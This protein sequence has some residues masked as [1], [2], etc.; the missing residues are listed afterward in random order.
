MFQKS[1]F[2]IAGPNAAPEGTPVTTFVEPGFG[3][4]D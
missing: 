1:V 4:T 3:N 2:A